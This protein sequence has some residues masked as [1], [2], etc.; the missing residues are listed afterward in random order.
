MDEEF[1]NNTLL[2]ILKAG[3]ELPT[4]PI[5]A[6][7]DVELLAEVGR[8]QAILPILLHGM[9]RLDVRGEALERI[10]QLSMND[11]YQFAYRDYA[12][13]HICKC[14][15]AAQIPYVLLKGATLRE[16]YPEQWMRTSSD[17]DVLIHEE[18]IDTAAVALEKHTDFRK[19]ERHY[20][21]V[22]FKNEKICL[23]LH[24]SIMETMEKADPLLKR[25]WEYCERTEGAWRYA[26]RP[27]FQVFHT[28]A[29]M[30]YHLT[31]GGLGIRPYLDLW[32]LRHRTA[33]DAEEAA[34][35]CESAGLGTFYEAACRLADAWLSDGE[36]TALTCSLENLCFDGGVFGNSQNAA[37][38][39]I[40]GRGKLGFLLHRLFPPRSTMEEQYPAVKKHLL[41]LPFY[42]VRRLLEGLVKK[43]KSSVDQLR[44]VR[45]AKL[46]EIR[47]MDELMQRLEL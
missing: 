7:I 8:R 37:A 20:H 32:L 1:R 9:K 2:P 36:Q 14:F 38:L 35:L 4:E 45:R 12:V 31:H 30:A 3:L 28:T 22:L 21:D 25:V 39:G 34:A 46:D 24:F 23:E 27:A 29:H 19:C 43:R 10:E 44:R 17:I 5:T 41:L 11:L 47:S 40:R 26:M 16:L 18:D 15:E 13:E 42:Y 33:F 6:P